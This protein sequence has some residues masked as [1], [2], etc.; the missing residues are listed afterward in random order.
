MF[1]RVL[2]MI[3]TVSLVSVFFPSPRAW[4]QA[5]AGEPDALVRAQTNL[6]KPLARELLP[7]TITDATGNPIA[8]ITDAQ[9]CGSNGT[10]ARVLAQITKGPSSPAAANLLLADCTGPLS[11]VVSRHQ[12]G[13][14]F[15]GVLELTVNWSNWTL[16]RTVA[17]GAPAT[18]TT[19]TM[20][21]LATIR[22]YSN[23]ISTDRVPITSGNSVN[24]AVALA[25]AFSKGTITIGVF[26]GTPTLHFR[27][28]GPSYGCSRRQ[29]AYD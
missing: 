22:Q 4:A 28:V 23:R 3:A 10:G 25:F 9:Y 19:F 29:H 15:S 7:K 6:A 12:A 2:L 5:I 18:P 20:P 11:S 26:Q 8:V 27:L 14:G 21:E 16:S 24:E 13:I 17:A 1:V